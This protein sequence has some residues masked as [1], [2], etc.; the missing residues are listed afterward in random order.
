MQKIT[1]EGAKH[2]LLDGTSV[3]GGL[4]GELLGQDCAGCIAWR[5]GLLVQVLL[6][7]SSLL[8]IA[9][10]SAVLCNI[11]DRSSELLHLHW[12]CM[13]RRCVYRTA[14]MIGMTLQAWIAAWHTM[15]R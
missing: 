9:L 11:T 8:G 15:L 10:E 3:D 1:H 13:V 12:A 14:G 7:A 6:A 2:H 5:A 4:G